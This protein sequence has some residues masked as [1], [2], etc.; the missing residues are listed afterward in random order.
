MYIYIYLFSSQSGMEAPRLRVLY[1][2]SNST[3]TSFWY[4]LLVS[5]PDDILKFVNFEYKVHLNVIAPSSLWTMEQF[6]DREG[7]WFALISKTATQLM[8]GA[9]RCSCCPASACWSWPLFFPS[10]SD[11]SHILK[12]KLCFL[13]SPNILNLVDWKIMNQNLSLLTAY[14]HTCVC[15]C[16]LVA[17]SCPNLCDPH[18]L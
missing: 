1:R 10:V 7:L 2:S 3:V 5:F 17:Q 11:A 15:V 4:V 18:E 12:L 8:W 6:T 13:L 9:L 16:V 14:R